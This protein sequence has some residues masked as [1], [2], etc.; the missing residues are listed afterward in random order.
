MK[1]RL[2]KFCIL[3]QNQKAQLK[4]KIGVCCPLHCAFVFVFVYCVHYYP[5]H[6]RKNAQELIQG[7]GGG[8]QAFESRRVQSGCN[9]R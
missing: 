5:P 1:K 7:T 2:I 8:L 6:D 4:L 9:S 3:N